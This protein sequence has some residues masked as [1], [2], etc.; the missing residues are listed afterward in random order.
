MLIVLDGGLGSLRIGE[1][2]VVVGRCNIDP[3]YNE[4]HLSKS[5]S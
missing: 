1:E 2:Q 4:A 5:Q 3:S